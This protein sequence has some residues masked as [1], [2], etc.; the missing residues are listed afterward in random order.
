MLKN[1]LL[2]LFLSL[3]NALNYNLCVIGATSSLGKEIIYR[4]INEKNANVLALSS[5]PNSVIYKPYRGNGFNEGSTAEFKHKNFRVDSYWNYITDTYDNIVFCTSAKP[6]KKDYSDKLIDKYLNILP[7]NCKN[8]VLV[9]AYGVGNSI[10]N[11]N[12]GI[13]IMDS[14]YLKDV[15][16]AKNYQ[17]NSLNMYKG[18][19]RKLIYRPKALS[20]GKTVLQSTSR[21]ELAGQIINHLDI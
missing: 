15:Y 4:A 3:N 17:E 19:V 21:Y 7:E 11:A 16:R 8:I 1:L 2:T 14:L 10:T 12:V 6:F 18:S 20:Y 9:S 5:S 13:K